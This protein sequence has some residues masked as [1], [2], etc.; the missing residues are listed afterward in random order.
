MR[1]TSS[2]LAILPVALE[3]GYFRV[4]PLLEPL[5]YGRRK[6]RSEQREIEEMPG[7]RH[8]PI[9]EAE[10]MEARFVLAGPDTPAAD[11]NQRLSV[12][13]YSW[14]RT[15]SWQQVDDSEWVSDFE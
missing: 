13:R 10:D 5:K 8:G 9:I 12:L 2:F 14:D 1:C 15:V 3:N 6:I 11:P 7:F 4:V